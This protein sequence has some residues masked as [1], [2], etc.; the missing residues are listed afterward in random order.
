MDKVIEYEKMMIRYAK[1]KTYELAAFVADEEVKYKNYKE[2]ADS[3][4]IQANDLRAEIMKEC[5]T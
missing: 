5:A 4:Q 2:L 1:M 3:V